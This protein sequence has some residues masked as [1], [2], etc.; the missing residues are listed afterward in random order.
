MIK[1]KLIISDVTLRDGNHAVNHSISREIIK[2]YCKEAEKANIK[3]IEVGHGNGLG[4]SSLS[5]GKSLITDEVALTT[6]RKALKKAKLSIHSIPGFSRITDLQKAI[7]CGVDIF[8]IGTNSS[9]IDTVYS[10]VKFC[11]KK[12]VEV[13]GVLMMAHLVYNKKKDYLK[14]IKY[15]VDLGVKTIIIMD[16]AGIFLP[17]DIKEIFTN[18]KKKFKVNLGF[19]GHNNFGTAVWNSVIA[20]KYGAKIIDA[21][22]KGFGAGAGN[23]QLDILATVMARFN[24]KTNINLNKLYSLAKV[25]PTYFK[26][27]VIKYKNPYSEPKN[28]MSANYGLFS[29]F[30]SKV[31]YYSN[32][33][34]LDD[35]EAFKAIGKKKLVAGQEDLI[36]NALYNL[37][38]KKINFTR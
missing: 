21:S 16:S 6:A 9:E 7:D 26:K 3:I 34:N 15:L 5:I 30:A 32:K 4:A 33:L 24:M 28:I 29:G 35:I 27:N 23:T 18:I 38:K 17:G 11:N 31:D 22:I 36:I 19:H 10:Q 12:K 2:K 1:N 14:K 20:H 8:R 25:F 13:W 37:K